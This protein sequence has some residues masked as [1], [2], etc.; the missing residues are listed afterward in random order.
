MIVSI[1]ERLR[2]L[3]KEKGLNIR[4]FAMRVRTSDVSMGHIVS[5]GEGGRGSKPSC[6]L[7][8]KIATEFPDVSMEWLIR[9]EGAMIKP[10]IPETNPEQKQTINYL[11]RRV[12]QLEKELM[13]NKKQ[14][15]KRK[16]L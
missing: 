5:T 9:G 13:P 7:L 3:M 1:N 6:E 15:L 11:L 12:S 2:I 14:T 10:A 4:S 16:A 8:E